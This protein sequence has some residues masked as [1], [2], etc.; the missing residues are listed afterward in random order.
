MAPCIPQGRLIP[1]LARTLGLRKCHPQPQVCTEWLKVAIGVKQCISSI[2]ALG[3]NDCVDGLANLE[4]KS[5]KCPEVLRSLDG[6]IAAA[7]INKLERLER[8]PGLVEVALRAKALQNFRC[9]EITH[10]DS[11]LRK[12]CVKTLNL[13]GVFSTEE[14]YP[15]ACVYKNHLSVLIA[16]RSPSH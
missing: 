13:R 11:L 12:E 7:Q 5:L 8:L 3:G 16:S 1:R 2:N 15:D 10:R 4:P 14:V 9:N 6:N